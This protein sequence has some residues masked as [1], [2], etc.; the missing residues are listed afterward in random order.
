[1]EVLEGSR[2]CEAV[3]VTRVMEREEGDMVTLQVEGTQDS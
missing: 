1:M 3:S 2:Q